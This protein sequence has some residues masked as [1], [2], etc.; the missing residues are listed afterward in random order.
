M[1][2]FRNDTDTHFVVTYDTLAATD[3]FV[4]AGGGELDRDGW[5]RNRTLYVDLVKVDGQYQ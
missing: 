5:L 4:V 2:I 3:E 1:S